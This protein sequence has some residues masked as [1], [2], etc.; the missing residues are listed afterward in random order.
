[1]KDR[2]GREIDYLR[3]S[4]IDTCN[5]RCVYCMPLKGLR[6]VPSEELLTAADIELV[7]RA[8]VTVGFRRIRLTGGEPTL[9]PDLVD[10]V[11]RLAAV[12]GLGEVAMTTNAVLLPRLARPL[13]QAGLR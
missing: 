8:A 7:A 3:V 2:F 11:R 1:M 12:P 10:I 13:A 6:F 9:R 5:L 4:V